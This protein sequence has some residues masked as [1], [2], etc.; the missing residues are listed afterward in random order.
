[1]KASIEI[2]KNLDLFSL[3][4]E[5]ELG[6]INSISE[7]VDY[8][9]GETIVKEGIHSESL[10]IIK[11]GC[12]RVTKDSRLIVILG[13]GSLIGELSFIDKGLPSAT[14]T[15]EQD[16]RLIRIPLSIFDN[17]LSENK[18]MEGKLYKSFALTLCQKLRD[19]N[20]WLSTEK[21]LAEVEK[22]ALSRFHI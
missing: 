10:F 12:V 20:E 6:K 7:E 2:L 8:R 19:T 17:L 11:N 13:E 4:D 22:Q 14:V 3:L 5:E 9:K 18:G 16:S 15:A 21:W 1:M